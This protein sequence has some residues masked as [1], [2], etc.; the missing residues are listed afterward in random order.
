MVQL[1]PFA[2]SDIDQLIAWI[3]SPRFCLQWAGP[4]FAWPLERQ[5]ILEDEWRDAKAESPAAAT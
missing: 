1:D 3:D 5:R 2:A 4:G